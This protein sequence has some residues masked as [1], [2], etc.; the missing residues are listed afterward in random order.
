[1]PKNKFSGLNISFV[2]TPQ[3]TFLPIRRDM[4][5]RPDWYHYRIANCISFFTH[6]QLNQ[7]WNALLFKEGIFH[8]Q[9]EVAYGFV[10]N[11]TKGFVMVFYDLNVL[12]FLC[13]LSWYIVYFEERI[14]RYYARII[15]CKINISD[16]RISAYQGSQIIV[17]GIFCL[18][19]SWMIPRVIL[20][21]DFLK[22]G[23]FFANLICYDLL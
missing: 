5:D 11:I 16:S 17:F 18:R 4:K 20:G 12:V 21:N 10:K 13:I 6:L 15:F 19:T 9:K 1:M 7:S 22:T 2:L 3:I 14:I 8:C 23:L